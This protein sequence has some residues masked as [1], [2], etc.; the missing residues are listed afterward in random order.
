MSCQTL[1]SSFRWLL[2]CSIAVASYASGVRL[3]HAC[4]A[5]IMIFA[6][7]LV[8]SWL[9]STTLLSAN[10]PVTLR[11]VGRHLLPILKATLLIFCCLICCNSFRYAP[12]ACPAAPKES[13]YAYLH[14]CSHTFLSHA[15]HDHAVKI[16]RVHTT[17]FAVMLAQLCSPC[18]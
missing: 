2:T 14:G 12:A 18:C 9:S 11:N 13:M 10:V 15:G 3:S 17:D 6:Y 1:A 8:A 4:I 16:M 7:L 5:K